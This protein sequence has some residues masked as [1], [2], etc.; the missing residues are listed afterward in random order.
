MAADVCPEAV[1]SALPCGLWLQA[2]LR[3]LAEHNTYTCPVCMKSIMT[4]ANME[5]IWEGMDSMVAVRTPYRTLHRA[6]A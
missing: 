3:S 4:A 1:V 2:C 6:H 5:R